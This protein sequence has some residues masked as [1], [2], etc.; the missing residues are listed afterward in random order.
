MFFHTF[1]NSSQVLSTSLPTQLLLKQE[2]QAMARWRNQLLRIEDTAQ[3]VKCLLQR[4]EDLNPDHPYKKPG[5]TD[6]T[7]NHSTTQGKYRQIKGCVGQKSNQTVSWRFLWETLSQEM[8]E[9]DG[10]HQC[11]PLASTYASISAH[12]HTQES[13]YQSLVVD[14]LWALPQKVVRR[15]PFCATTSRLMPMMFVHATQLFQSVVVRLK[16][17]CVLREQ[18]VFLMLLA[19]EIFL[20]SSHKGCPSPSSLKSRPEGFLNRSPLASFISLASIF[21]S[22]HQ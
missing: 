1:H 20:Q 2:G 9:S 10:R 13:G 22:T 6:C 15:W 8:R 5:T 16:V 19:L 11:R 21:P 12:E 4:H 7:C 18:L 3:R 17:G 14:A